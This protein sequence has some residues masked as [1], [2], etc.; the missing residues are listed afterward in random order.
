MWLSLN[1]NYG[2]WFACLWHNCPVEHRFNNMMINLKT[3]VACA[4]TL[5][6]LLLI[7]RVVDCH[8]CC[9]NCEC[10][11]ANF[12][13]MWGVDVVHVD[14][15]DNH[16]REWCHCTAQ[17]SSPRKNTVVQRLMLCLLACHTNQPSLTAE[18]ESEGTRQSKYWRKEKGSRRVS[19]NGR[20][21]Q[22]RW[23]KTLWLCAN[24]R[25]SDDV[26]GTAHC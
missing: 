21:G 1:E 10:K 8:C 20:S 24:G 17:K 6:G 16:Y 19:P 11:D 12:G 5:S 2:A 4:H 15:L 23:R 13:L 25:D 22:E 3:W 7:M 14:I 18:R 9:A 26:R